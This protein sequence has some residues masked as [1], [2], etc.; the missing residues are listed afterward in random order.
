MHEPSIAG[1]H[2]QKNPTRTRMCTHTLCKNCTSDIFYSISISIPMPAFLTSLLGPSKCY[3]L[4]LNCS[5][6]GV[7]LLESIGREVAVFQENLKM[8]KKPLVQNT[9]IFLWP[10]LPPLCLEQ[11]VSNI[12]LMCLSFTK[13]RGCG[14]PTWNL[15]G[16]CACI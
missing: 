2:T 16:A 10:K 3:F 4:D 11:E 13:L 8:G 9:L 14:D 15:G 5:T 1:V 7:W 12:T 6:C